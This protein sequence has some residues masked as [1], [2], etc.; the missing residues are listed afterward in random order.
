MRKN[1]KLLKN[2]SLLFL[3]I[4]FAFLLR[5]LWL[6]RVP[7]AISNDELDYV[8][9]AK[10]LFLSG[11][12]ISGKW[13]PLSL[14]TPPAQVPKAELPSLIV[15]PLI[16]PFKLSLLTSRL[17]FVIWGLVLIVTLF[18]IT[19]RFWGE[20]AA[21][22][23]AAVA[24]INPWSF[25][26]SRTAFDIPL[27]TTFYYLAFYILLS[28]AGW[29]ILIAFPFLFLAFFSYIGM[30]L[31]FIPFVLIICF[32]SWFFINKR[33]FTKQYLV[34]VLLSLVVF[35]WFLI[36][37]RTGLVKNRT[38]ELLTPFHPL[39]VQ[40]VE[41]ERRLSVENPLILL[42]SN[43]AVVF[44]KLFLEKYLGSFSLDFLFIHGEGRAT[45]SVWYH[46][47]FYYLDLIFLILGLLFLF[48]SNKRILLL[49]TSLIMIAPI[50]AAMSTTGEEYAL[51]GALLYPILILLIGLGI[52]VVISLK[53]NRRF[54][55][56]VMVLIMILYSL[57][58]VNFLNIY[59]FRNPIYNSE[60]FGF[61]NRVLFR[62]VSL[63][64]PKA[65]KVLVITG[66]K[67]GSFKQNLFYSNDYNKST[68][69]KVR[70]VLSQD[71]YQW[72]NIHFLSSCPKDLILA[73][74]EVAILLPESRCLDDK[75]YPAWLSISQLSDG[76]EV[77]RIFN[78]FLCR[79]FKLNRYP[80]GIEFSDFEVE[81]LS[82]VQFCQKFISD[83]TGF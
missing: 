53:K 2:Y 3:I 73:K 75:E 39:V 14:T 1:K 66:D 82:T 36:S 48:V 54:R 7:I 51:R 65:G 16:G 62:Y 22:I 67:L 56:G 34:L 61:S 23:V 10:S 20:K 5:I 80:V 21:L 72:G 69:V 27:A 50:P 13:S 46:G 74:D 70:E 38:S 77:Y 11:R 25:Y 78:D 4:I 42:F 45:Y 32:Y 79:D 55:I 19:K 76:G 81:K 58:L 30:K 26:F 47:L 29:K 63:V 41:S 8:L 9:D 64:K 52:W 24:S 35:A 49:L 60:G 28:F 83:L 12:D 18:L 6:D 40:T 31:I 37:L 15:S 59:F 57:Q 71:K 68:L 33:R 43:K 44:G 17:P